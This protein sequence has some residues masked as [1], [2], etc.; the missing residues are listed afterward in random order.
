MP[1]SYSQEFRTRAVSAVLL[2][3]RRLA[4]YW[5]TN[6]GKPFQKTSL[7][8]LRESTTLISS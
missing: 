1:R 2:Y 8:A 4:V 3:A 7:T 5:Q 6:I